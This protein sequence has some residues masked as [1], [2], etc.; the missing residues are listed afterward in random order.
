MGGYSLMEVKLETATLEY[1]GSFNLALEGWT[2]KVP[3]AGNAISAAITTEVGGGGKV[4]WCEC[5]GGDVGKGCDLRFCLRAS[6]RSRGSSCTCW[7]LAE[8]LIVRWCLFRISD[9]VE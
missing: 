2:T 4:W 8:L 9:R 1:G 3:H 5:G 7:K 6:S